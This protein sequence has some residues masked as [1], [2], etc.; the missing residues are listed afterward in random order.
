MFRFLKGVVFVSVFSA[1][2]AWA[3]PGVVI[4]VLLSPTGSYKAKTQ[5]VTGSA[6]KTPDGGVI[7]ENVVVDM[8]SI[9]TGIGLRDK[10]TKERLKTDK[11]KEAKLIKATGKD[12]KGTG[13]ME[14]MGK[15]QK[16]EGTY[17]IEGNMLKAD[18]PMNL[19][20]LDI[21]D[22]RYM[23]VGVKDKVVVHV[24]LPIK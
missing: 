8:Q 20:D 5:K 11:F 10:H 18:F 14:I 3:E 1:G 17:K 16:V 24:E 13:E 15:K 7:A 12:G 22:V 6:K 9:K 19:K 23:G 2:A 4:D 21:K